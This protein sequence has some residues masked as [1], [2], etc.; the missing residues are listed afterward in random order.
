MDDQHD[1]GHASK[2][3]ACPTYPVAWFDLSTGNCTCGGRHREFIVAE[4]NGK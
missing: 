4:V 2:T 1:A 3:H